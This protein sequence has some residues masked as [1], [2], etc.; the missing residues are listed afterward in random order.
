MRKTE[1]VWILS[2]WRKYE[3]SRHNKST[4]DECGVRVWW[5]RVKRMIV[6]N[7]KSQEWR[8]GK[9]QRLRERNHAMY[10]YA[11]AVD[12]HECY[13]ICRARRLKV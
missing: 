5:V 9:E 2:S 13:K 3:Y 1:D 7:E 12:V 11:C 4:A 10:S 6:P 8:E